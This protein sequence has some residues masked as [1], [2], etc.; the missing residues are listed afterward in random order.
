MICCSNT[1]FKISVLI[2]DVTVESE[3]PYQE[4]GEGSIVLSKKVQSNQGHE[5]LNM[6]YNVMK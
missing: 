3:V 6:K 1:N 4:I 5:N 2:N